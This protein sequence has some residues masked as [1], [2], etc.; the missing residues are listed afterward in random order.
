MSTFKVQ[1]SKLRWFWGYTTT[2]HVLVM[3]NYRKKVY[4][5]YNKVYM[6]LRK[7]TDRQIG[8]P[9][10]KTF[11]SAVYSIFPLGEVF[12]LLFKMTLCWNIC[13]W[14]S[15]SYRGPRLSG[16]QLLR[17]LKYQENSIFRILLT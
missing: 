8:L 9:F 1:A 15:W 4:Y 7:T 2:L 10:K 6:Y 14:A 3:E 12:G 17:S 13:I 5:Y 16:P 11:S